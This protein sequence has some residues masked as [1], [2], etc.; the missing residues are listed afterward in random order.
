M[1]FGRHRLLGLIGEGGMDQVY[2]AHD[3]VIG[4]DVAVKVLPPRLGALDGY[5]DRFRR[6]ATVAARL[7]E[8]HIVPIYDTGETDG[9]LY[10]V[11]PIIEGVD[12][13][14]VLRRE[15]RLSPPRAVRVIQ[16]LAAA[17]NAAHRNG[18]V[19]RDVKP[20]NALVTGDDH[21]YLI[22]F[23]VAHDAAATRITQTGS[24]LGTFAYMAPERFTSGS[25]DPRTDVYSLTCLLYECLTGATP[26]PGNSMHQQITGHLTVEPPKPTRCDPRVPP[27]FDDVVAR[28][29]AK[30]P[31]ERY[32]SVLELA[33]A[34]QRALRLPPGPPPM[35][36]G[37][38]RRDSPPASAVPPRAER[39]SARTVAAPVSGPTPPHRPPPAHRPGMATQPIGTR[40]FTVLLFGVVWVSCATAVLLTTWLNSQ[41]SVQFGDR[42]Q[43]YAVV[44]AT[45][46][47]IALL[48]FGR[49]RV[50][51]DFTVLGCA[52]LALGLSA[53]VLALRPENG[54]LYRFY[55]YDWLVA[56]ASVVPLLLIIAALLHSRPRLALA[57]GIVAVGFTILMLA[58]FDEVLKDVVGD[59]YLRGATL[60]YGAFPGLVMAIAGGATWLLARREGRSP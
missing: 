27:A 17:L 52:L 5:R 47:G 39:D 50:K 13:R 59:F 56:I 35:D 36:A 41:Y 58:M 38:A 24:M 44:F 8:P 2:K 34:A 23:G 11:M 30:H 20:S 29:M 43:P 18:L 4:R 22:D 3:T 45:L 37:V 28:G 40:R 48:L 25:T 53:L 42:A 26:F 16:Q 15:G 33:A 51:A 1:A 14:T 7:T 21:V 6:E 32:Q 49:G 60:L 9:H 31:E 19:H 12:L 57:K 10:L 55:A 46:P 54:L